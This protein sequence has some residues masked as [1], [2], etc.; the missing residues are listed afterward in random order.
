MMSSVRLITLSH[1]DIVQRLSEL[2]DILIDCVNGGASVSFMQPF[3][4]DKASA[5]WQNVAQSVAANSRVVLAVE[6]HDG[7]LVGTVQLIVDLA[8]NQ[9]HRA[10]VAKLLVHSRGRRQGIA[11]L[12]MDALEQEAVR[13]GKSVLVLDT[14]TGS[15]AESFYQRCGW[16]K[17]GEIPR[18]ALMPDGVMTATSVFY[19][20]V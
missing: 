13:Q 15:G 11:R 19:K 4:P 5:F 20:F 6:Q 17:A 1:H 7:Q 16:Q 3:H 12:L 18:F 14:A 9:P 8:E 2:T 10:E